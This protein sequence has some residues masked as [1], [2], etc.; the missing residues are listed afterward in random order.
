MQGSLG[1]MLVSLL[2]YTGLGPSDVIL[3]EL[4]PETDLDQPK[5]LQIPSR[6]HPSISELNQ[7]EL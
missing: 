3:L 5:L 4:R 7:A 1:H 6:L 2:I